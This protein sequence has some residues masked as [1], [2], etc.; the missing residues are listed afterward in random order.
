MAI[1]RSEISI[2]SRVERVA[3]WLMSTT[4]P[5]RFISRITCRPMRVMPGSSAS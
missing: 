5:T 3:E 4:M 1:G 2:A